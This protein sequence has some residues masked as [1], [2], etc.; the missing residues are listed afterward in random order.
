MDSYAKLTV[1]IPDNIDLAEARKLIGYASEEIISYKVKGTNEIILKLKPDANPEDIKKTVNLVLTQYVP[2]DEGCVNVYTYKRELAKYWDKEYILNSE[3]VKKVDNGSISFKEEAERLFDFFDKRFG[4]IA[5]EAG[6]EKRKYPVLLPLNTYKRTGYLKKSPQYAIFC[7]DLEEN[8]NKIMDIDIEKPLK[9]LLK[10]PGAALSPSACFHVY[11][12]IQDKLLDKPLAITLVQDVF[13]NE[14]RFNWN[15]YGRLKCYTIREL[16]FIGDD[17]YVETKIRMV[18]DKI[19]RILEEL[20]LNS[21]ITISSDAFIAP[22]FQKLKK[23]QKATKCKYEVRIKTGRNTDLACASLNFHGVSFSKA[24]KFGVAGINPTVSGCI[25]F[26]IERWVLAFLAQ[27]GFEVNKW[28][29]CVQKFI[30]E[31]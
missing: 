26:G 6:C 8:I 30:K 1:E 19:K 18:E 9:E 31:Q 13:R 17:K 20:D 3:K 15:E 4:E 25:G 29:E 24:F 12:E 16:V 22:E 5:M 7:C 23:I 11:N 14:G 21:K 28:P 2:T 10:H 27:Y